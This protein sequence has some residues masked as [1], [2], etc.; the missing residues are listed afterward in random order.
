[1]KS[2]SFIFFISLLPFLLFGQTGKLKGL[3]REL[4]SGNPVEKVQVKLIPSN[5]T[6][7]TDSTGTF[8][9]DNLE[10]G[11][12]SVIFTKI[13]YLQH[14]IPCVKIEADSTAY[15]RIIME[16]VPPAVK[17]PLEPTKKK[18]TK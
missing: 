7:E 13:G 9:F 8:L 11:E 14:V 16:K 15:L 6:M 5:R 12:Y 17:D 18:K 1:M 4:Y 2:L 10:V 3:V